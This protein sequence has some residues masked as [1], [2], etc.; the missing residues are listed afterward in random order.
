MLDFMKVSVEL[1]S[2]KKNTYYVRPKFKVGK[3]KDLLI[4]GGDFYAIWDEAAGFWSTDENTAIRLIDQEIEQK[5]NEL[6][7]EE[8]GKTY[9]PQY[10]WDAD[11][12]LIKTFHQFCKDDLRDNFVQLDSHLMFGG[13]TKREDYAS[14]ALPYTLSNIE[15]P[16]Y[17]ELIST[18]YAPKER[19]K[20]EWAIGSIVAGDSVHIQKFLVFYGSHGTGKSTI[21]HIIENL[22][23]GYCA[24][25]DAKSIGSAT[26]VFA[27][28]QFRD[29][30]L[31]AIQHDGDLSH[32]EDNSRLNSLISHE[33]M[34]MNV[35]YQSTYAAQ[36][37]A[38]LFMGTNRPVKIT[39]ARS[40]L[41]RRLIDV[42]PTGNKIPIGRYNQLF[43]TASKFELG[44]IAR[45]CREVYL[46][47][48]HYYDDYE[49]RSMLEITNDFYG[50]VESNYYDWKKNNCVGLQEAWDLY[51][52]Y[53]TESNL[54]YP[55]TKKVFR[56]ELKAYFEEI[57][58]T[59]IDESGK[60]VRNLYK[61]FKTEIF[62]KTTASNITN[63]ASWL[64]FDVET[65]L[66]DTQYADCPAQLANSA[67]TPTCKW[68]N[69]KTK[70]SDIDTSKLH[71][72]RVPENLITIDFDIPDENGEKCFALNL[73]EAEK[74]PPTYAELS[75]S[76][77][78]IH[79]EYIY[80]GDVDKLAPLYKEHI[81]VKVFKG[82]S[83][84]RRMVTKCNDIPIRTIDS[85]LPVKENEER[86]MVD[87]QTI[88][89]EAKL[90]ALIKKAL[91]KK[92]TK[93]P[94]ST[95]CNIDFI[96]AILMK[97]YNSGLVYDVSDMK[98]H[99]I[100]FALGSTHNAQYCTT[101]AS[102][103]RFTSVKET[104][105]D[106]GDAPLVFY[107]IEVFPNVYFVNWKFYGVNGK[108]TRWINPGKHE[109]AQLLRYNIIGFNN[110]R[111]DNALLW[112]ML[113]GASPREIYDLSQRII[114]KKD[115]S[116]I[117]RESKKLSYT[118]V[119]DFSSTKKSLKKW[120]I[121]IG[122]LT[123]EY[124]RKK[125]YTEEEI[126]IIKAGGSH[127]E[128]RFDW[129]KDLPEEYWPEV[130][131]Y[132]DND[133]VNT[134]ATFVY[135]KADWV[136][137]QILADMAHGTVNDTT[138]DLTAKMIFGDNRNP[139]NEF[140]WRDMADE[141]APLGNFVPETDKDYSILSV[142]DPEWTKFDKYGRAI[143]PGYRYDPRLK[144]SYYR[145]EEIGEGGYVYSE[146]GLH[147]DTALLDVMSMHPH[148]ALAEQIFGPRYTAKY[149]ELIHAR[150]AVKHKDWD[151]ARTMLGGVLAP[152][153]D[154]V[155][156][157]EITNKDL[158]QALKIAINAVYGM[159][160]A[161][162]DN[163]F[164]DKRNIDNIVAKRG[165][166][167]MIN[168]KNEVQRRG[169]TVAHIKTD[170]IKIA[171]ADD[172]IIKF[173][174]E[175]G[176]LYGYTFEHEATYER[177]CL[178]N[179]A[180][181]I[182]SAVEGGYPL[183]EPHD[184]RL[185]EW[186]AV[187]VDFAIPYVWKTLFS[188]EDLTFDDLCMTCESKYPLVLRHPDGTEEF[189]GKNGRFVPVTSGGFELLS[190]NDTVDPP[191]YSAPARTKGYLWRE[192]EEFI[193]SNGSADTIDMRRWEEDLDSAKENIQKYTGDYEQFMSDRPYEK[194]C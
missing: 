178:I 2:S 168:L 122:G 60:E 59:G 24:N 131:E 182:S 19:H 193:E 63:D 157:G 49:P 52:A 172:S 179:K 156:R 189:V 192:A 3:P 121:V 150:V 34:S 15:T 67:G 90:R 94:N 95:R 129:S 136:A 44:G 58:E 36:F 42:S 65:S 115:R 79:L 7:K 166:L 4:K 123:K 139:Q 165:E 119:Y 80:T 145:G 153:I 11:T 22:F 113:N 130:S 187:G 181:Y 30:P 173:V 105:V 70:L 112:L 161:A 50:F 152:Y 104:V 12:R 155:L 21:L 29:N 17:N 46:E 20:I 144:K 100:S 149:M 8:N 146:P 148:S 97:A 28:E 138:N 151:K 75:K 1:A 127:K 111:Y 10:I 163:I 81:E 126:E 128:S 68:D 125:G 180:V 45:H 98:G 92:L 76:G 84:L 154:K 116:A 120:E 48:T 32:I 27:L 184:K 162:F 117:P 82:N 171:N 39:D 164:K 41:L 183:D 85:G 37:H 191:H 185:G 194:V 18:L 73:K 14:K 101:V 55:F 141:N 118:D 87:N 66:F 64:H 23:E 31:V 57:L 99:V 137:R 88:E 110:L 102:N 83:S 170:S 74:F 107:D 25:F 190:R 13:P 54:Q 124:L 71:Y 26:N 53:V 43:N 9:I 109:I 132:C 93:G 35:K 86:N 108:K 140:N 103:M 51:K 106:I 143:F 160:S 89:T 158:A 72:V 33:K 6:I 78:G 167:F 62:T 47:N 174:M 16:A 188:H 176:K 38:M 175:Y 69:C 133:V 177:F 61:G 186:T 96:N 142:C 169:Y 5:Y 56:E 114:V 40:G 91:A 134:E 159:T 147:V 135:L 77:Q